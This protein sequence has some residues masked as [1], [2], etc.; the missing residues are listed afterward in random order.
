MNNSNEMKVYI[1]SEMPKEE[2]DKLINSFGR[3][4]IKQDYENNEK[5]GFYDR[6]CKTD[7]CR[8]FNET[9]A[10]SN[11]RTI[12][13]QNTKIEALQNV[14]IQQNQLLVQIID[15]IKNI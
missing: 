15:K 3:D 14:V 9:K 5:E 4:E 11:D 7:H 2:R 1:L 10:K 6:C 13:E 12:E 8:I